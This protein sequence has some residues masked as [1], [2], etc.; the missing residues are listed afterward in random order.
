ME[1][2]DIIIIVLVLVL[3][4]GLG[5]KSAEQSTCKNIKPIEKLENISINNQNSIDIDPEKK[6]KSITKQ[7]DLLKDGAFSDVKMYY[8]EPVWGEMTGLQKCMNEC[9][10]TCTEFGL[11]GSA[12]CFPRT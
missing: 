2:I 7:V 3:V 9:R 10:G 1:A 12:M 5:Q 6:T 11:S 8:S 4:Y